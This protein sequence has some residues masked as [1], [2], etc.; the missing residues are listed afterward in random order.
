MNYELSQCAVEIPCRPLSLSQWQRWEP[1]PPAL[2]V[3]F[4]N[5]SRRR[6]GGRAGGE[7]PQ[8]VPGLAEQVL[9]GSNI[10][11]SAK[12]EVHLVK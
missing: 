5:C 1:D 11:L 6:A 8:S 10:F 7:H 3:G 9:Q 2:P 4:E 12:S